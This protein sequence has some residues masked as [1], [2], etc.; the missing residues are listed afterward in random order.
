MTLET[1]VN[2]SV[3]IFLFLLLSNALLDNLTHPLSLEVASQETGPEAFKVVRDLG[4]FASTAQVSPHSQ[5]FRSDSRVSALL[6]ASE[7]DELQ[8]GL[9][10]VDPHIWIITMDLESNRS[11]SSSSIQDTCTC[12]PTCVG[13]IAFASR[14]FL[15]NQPLHRKLHNFPGCSPSTVVF[16]TT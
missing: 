10:V 15:S 14:S 16:W 1:L 2:S 9:V 7:V 4:S 13:V 11:R 5:S 3:S 6:S 8:V 12:F